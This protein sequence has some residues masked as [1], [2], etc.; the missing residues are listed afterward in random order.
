M[1]TSLEH[2][3]KTKQEQILQIVEIIK[4]VAVPEKIILFGS[5][6][7]GKWV[8]DNYIEKGIKYEY[9]SDYDFLVVTEDN[10][11]KDYVLK[12]IIVNRSHD[13]SKVPVNPIIHSISYVNEGLEFGQYFFADIIREGIIL[14]NTQK[15]DFSNPKELTP[16]EMRIVAQ[17]YFDQWF[18]SGEEFFIDANNAFKRNSLNHSA[19]YLHQSAERFYNTI[20][21]V[22]TGYKPK[23][24]NL[25]KLRRHAKNLSEELFL[26]FPYPTNDQHESHLFDL[27]KRGYID[28][29]YKEDYVISKNEVSI[30]ISRIDE[31]RKTVGRVCA[32]KISLLK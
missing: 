15:S 21:L 26:I 9:I 10:E 4:E 16:T 1:K 29:R 11:E 32:E 2:L 17:R 31:M 19:F 24:H 22:I 3:P 25:D 7:T 8:E 6:A 20:L 12:D 28:A 27:I 30:L 14:Y 5:Y 13:I 18:K 23:T